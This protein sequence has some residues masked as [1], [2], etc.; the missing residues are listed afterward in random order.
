M[1]IPSVS[2]ENR[3]DQRSSLSSKLEADRATTSSAMYA[4]RCPAKPSRMWPSKRKRRASHRH[5]VAAAPS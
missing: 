2:P 3:N 1:R 5:N 4:G